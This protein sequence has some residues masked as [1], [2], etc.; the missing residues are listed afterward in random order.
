[1]M[2]VPLVESNCRGH[3]E[4][5]RTRAGRGQTT[6]AKIPASGEEQHDRGEDPG[7]AEGVDPPREVGSDL[8]SNHGSNLGSNLGSNHGSVHGAST[9]T[10]EARR[11]SVPHVGETLRHA[12]GPRTKP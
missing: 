2:N 7:E 1:M 8:G 12:H 10:D 3:T 6:A 11:G 4:A 5:A 9:A